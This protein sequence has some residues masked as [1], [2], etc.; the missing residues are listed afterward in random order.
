[1]A[2]VIF[3]KNRCLL[4]LGRIYPGAPKPSLSR[5]EGLGAPF[6]EQTGIMRYALPFEHCYIA[7][8]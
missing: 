7:M 1:M 2:V 6:F 3:V 5:K 4:Q 8:T